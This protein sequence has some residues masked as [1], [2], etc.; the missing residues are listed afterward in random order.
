MIPKAILF[1]FDGTI[2]DSQPIINNYLFYIL[3][4]KG[5]VLS[6]DEKRLLG[7]IS[8]IDTRTWLEK[9]K[10]IIFSEFEMTFY[11]TWFIITQ[12]HKIKTF[13]G[14]K[15]MLFK[16]KSKG[17]KMAIVTNSPRKYT[18]YLIKKNHL[19][20]Y[21]DA[22]ITIDDA[23][24]PKPDPK[25]LQMAA[26]H[27]GVKYK[28]CIMVDDNKPGIVAGNKIGMQTVQVTTEQSVAKATIPHTK[29]LMKVKNI[30]L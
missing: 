2:I 25:M 28:E 20:G 10:K 8:L 6:K 23:G 27:L 18:H 7:G 13:E 15:Q 4:K 9:N 26:V 24:V 22:I 30:T 29:D 19:E 1:D 14:V 11:T 16:V 17:Y 5:I 12:L 3:K 21:F